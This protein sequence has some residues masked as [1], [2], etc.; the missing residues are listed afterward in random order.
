VRAFFYDTWAFI[1]LANRGDA[2]HDLCSE[3]DRSLEAMGYA[4]VTSDY[5][6]DETLTGLHV[7]AGAGVALAFLDLIDARIDAEDLMLLEVTSTRRAEAIRIFRRLCPQAP[8]LSFTDCTTFALMRELG[9][10]AAFTADRHFHLAGGG[11]RPLLDLR[12]GTL[13]WRSP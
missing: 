6:L 10:T 3:G 13:H 5:V 2:H 1:A 11:I 4:A 8:R 7:G 9:L 12:K